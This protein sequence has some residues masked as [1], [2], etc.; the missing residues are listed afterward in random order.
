[1]TLPNV[2]LKQRERLFV[3]TTLITLGSLAFVLRA[4]PFLLMF[5]SIALLCGFGS[6]AVAYYEGSS[7]MLLSPQH[8]A[9]A[10]L[11]ALVVA[12]PW[13]LMAA[14]FARDASIARLHLTGTNA[15]WSAAIAAAIAVAS[16]LLSADSLPR[17]RAYMLGFVIVGC[18]CLLTRSNIQLGSGDE[19]YDPPEETHTPAQHRDMA[20]F[21][22]V[23]YSG[24]CALGIYLIGSKRSLAK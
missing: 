12:I 24:A 14:F 11:P 4:P 8:A 16:N 19:D 9:R 3:G 20:L 21:D 6:L 1:M 5:A 13:C 7:L 10:W 23:L 2:L 17:A 18:I 15:L 22:F